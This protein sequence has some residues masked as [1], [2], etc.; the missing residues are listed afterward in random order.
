MAAPHAM[1]EMLL[2]WGDSTLILGH[3]LSEWCGHAPALEE[4]IAL[5]NV[6]LDLTGH[7]AQWLALAAEIEGGGRDA[8]ALAFRRDAIDFRNLLL[9]ELP[10]G[11]FAHTIVRQALFDAWHVGL[12]TALGD[13]RDERVAAI[14]AKAVKEARYHFRHSAEWTVRLGDGTAESHA[15]AQAALDSLWPYTGEMFADDDIAAAVACAGLAPLPS[16]LHDAWSESIAG[17]LAEATLTRPKDGWMQSGG[18]AGRHS[19][20]LGHLLATMQFLPRAYPDAR[21]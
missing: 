9:V 14:A 15:R 20:H 12:L 5:A 1:L 17:V 3:R 10:N 16:S 4:D 13:S 19:E 2:R 11:D 8:D 21:W 18:A 7:A 6:A